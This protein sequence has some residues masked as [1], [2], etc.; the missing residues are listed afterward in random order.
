M[1]NYCYNFTILIALHDPGTT[2]AQI[3]RKRKDAHLTI[4]C[5]SA[6]D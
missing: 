2:R 1:V 6:Y 4:G 3:N 5:L